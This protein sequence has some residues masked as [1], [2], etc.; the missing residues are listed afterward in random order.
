MEELHKQL[1]S[2]RKEAAA[3]L[4]EGATPLQVLHLRRECVRLWAAIASRTCAR[5]A[6]NS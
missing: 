2:L 5:S 6:R 4:K 1:A 3:L